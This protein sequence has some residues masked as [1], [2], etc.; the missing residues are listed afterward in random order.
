VNHRR[1][2]GKR[3][4]LL[5][6]LALLVLSAAAHAQETITLRHYKFNARADQLAILEQLAEEFHQ[7]HPHIRID[8]STGPE[9]PEYEENVKVMLAGGV[10]PDITEFYTGIASAM[11]GAGQFLDLRP[12]VEADPRWAAAQMT[13]AAVES[14]TWLDGT[15][16]MLPAVMGANILAY[17]GDLLAEAGFDHPSRLGDGWTWE[18]MMQMVQS[19]ARDDNADG[20]PERWGNMGRVGLARILTYMVQGGQFPFNSYVAPTSADFLAPGVQEGARFAANLLHPSIGTSNYNQFIQGNVGFI[21]IGIFPFSVELARLRFEPNAIDYRVS[22]WPIGPAGNRSTVMETRGWQIMKD[23]RYPDDAYEWLAFVHL[24]EERALRYAN[25]HGWIPA[26]SRL[27][28]TWLDSLG[29]TG[30]EREMINTAL[31][32]TVDP[33]N[34][35]TPFGPGVLEVTSAWDRSFADV[36]AEKVPLE[37]FLEQMNEVAKQQLAR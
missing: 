16:F 7:L 28:L 9:G 27:H 26:S 1:S 29:F 34:V 4:A 18:T 32:A 19:I 17:N 23:T 20:A 24:N 2:N 14:S 30:V 12:Y 25:V 35:P 10:P 5:L 36:V 3:I 15:L 13:P 8:I 21:W 31:E 33:G 11:A 37:T 22:P 6:A